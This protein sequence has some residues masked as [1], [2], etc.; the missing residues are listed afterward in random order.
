MSFSDQTRWRIYDRTSG[1]C[2]ICGRKLCF[3]NYGIIHARG[4][5][6]VEHSISWARGGTDHLNNLYAACIPCNRSKGTISTR[7]VRA[8]NGRTRAPLSRNRR[9]EIRNRNGWTG[10]AVG[11]AIGARVSPGAAVV[12]AIVGGL[13]GDSIKVK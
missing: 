11:A 12:C 3:Q 8:W 13:I 9:Q 6:E 5:W 10:V 4:A 7:T 2:H 1:Y